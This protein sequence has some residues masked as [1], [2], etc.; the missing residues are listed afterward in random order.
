MGRRARQWSLGEGT[1][2][3]LVEDYEAV[4]ARVLNG[5]A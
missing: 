2:E 5:G 4:Y 3:S 1:W